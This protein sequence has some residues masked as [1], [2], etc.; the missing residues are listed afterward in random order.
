MNGSLVLMRH[1]FALLLREPGP[2]LSR[3][4]MPIVLITAL[5]LLRE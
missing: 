5:R 3:I 1:N 4:G 2:V